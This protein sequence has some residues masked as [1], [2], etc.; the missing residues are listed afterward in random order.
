MLCSQSDFP[1]FL[2]SS[3]WSRSSSS[4]V[5]GVGKSTCKSSGQ[6]WYFYHDLMPPGRSRESV[7]FGGC[8]HPVEVWLGVIEGGV[9]LSNRGIAQGGSRSTDRGSVGLERGLDGLGRAPLHLISIL[10]YVRR[11]IRILGVIW[12]FTPSG[13]SNPNARRVVEK[14]G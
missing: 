7:L 10:E 14:S 1:H 9:V 3:H 6:E 2:V 5:I 8:K 12:P 13:G 11:E 4:V